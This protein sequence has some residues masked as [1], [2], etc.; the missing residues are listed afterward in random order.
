MPLQTTFDFNH[1]FGSPG[2][3]YGVWD[4]PVLTGIATED[5]PMGR[6]IALATMGGNTQENGR[7]YLK[8]PDTGDTFVGI[9]RHRQKESNS[10]KPTPK[11]QINSNELVLF[12][13]DDVVPYCP[14]GYFY[15]ET[16]EA[17]VPGNSVFV[18]TTV[19]TTRIEDLGKFNT[20]SGLDISANANWVT[21]TS[22]PGI[23]VV[24]ISFM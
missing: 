16:T 2:M 21:A 24:S 20:S 4:V 19:N 9:S 13:S 11:T 23:A 15:V 3:Q 1:E 14:I 5:I 12:E 17:V 7:S 6:G 18:S 22:G 8:L 10:D